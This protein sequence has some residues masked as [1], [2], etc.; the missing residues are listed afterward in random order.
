MNRIGGT[1]ERTTSRA[2]Y[3]QA[4]VSKAS[5]FQVFQS[6]CVFVPC[7]G[8]NLLVHKH[9]LY[10]AFSGQAKSLGSIS[11][12]PNNHVE[13]LTVMGICYRIETRSKGLLVFSKAPP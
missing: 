8:T 10:V 5:A 12:I 13:T 6:A 9:R 1:T 4:I 7:Q 3:Q 2:V 11:K